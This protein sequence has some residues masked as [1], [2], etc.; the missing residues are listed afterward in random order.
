M[1]LGLEVV[2]RLLATLPALLVLITI[3]GCTTLQAKPEGD[4]LAVLSAED[5]VAHQENS[6]FGAVCD[7]RPSWT[8][9][10]DPGQK[11]QEIRVSEIERIEYRHDK[12]G[13]AYILVV[14]KGRW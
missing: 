6:A 1:T 13:T 8:M 12:F 4:P 7:L 3:P 14:L 2:M 5:L 10:A 9:S 11:P